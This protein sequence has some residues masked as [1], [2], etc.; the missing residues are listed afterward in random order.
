ML[1]LEGGSQRWRAAAPLPQPRNHLAGVALNGVMYA[2]GGQRRGNERGGNL[3]YVHAY[4]PKTD[5]WRRVADLPY[6]VGHITAS[7]FAHDGKLVV[8]AA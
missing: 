5:R 2:L 8:T 3:R 4:D 7:S 6:R 1:D